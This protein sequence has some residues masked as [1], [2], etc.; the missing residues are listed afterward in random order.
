VKAIQVTQATAQVPITTLFTP[1]KVG[2][3]RYSAYMACDGPPQSDPPTGWQLAA[4]WTDSTG[5][6]SG[7]TLNC[8][9]QEGS[10]FATFGPAPFTPKA[11]V[12]LQFEV[13]VSAPPPVDST[14]TFWFTIEQLE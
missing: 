13:P 4:Y 7:V 14:Y 5:A 11:G 10:Q 9:L 6:K 3:Y 8:S 1:S 2:A 12:P